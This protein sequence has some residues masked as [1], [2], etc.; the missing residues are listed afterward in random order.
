MPAR[1]RPVP[2]WRHGFLVEW[3]TAPRS[4]W[5]REP[6]RA[7][8]WNAT[9]IW[10]TS[11]SLKSRPNTSSDAGSVLPPFLSLPTILSSMTL[12]LSPRGAR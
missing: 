9:T 8:A 10:C 3:R 4:F 6:M 11:D 2:F 12:S 1:A 7:F 5:A